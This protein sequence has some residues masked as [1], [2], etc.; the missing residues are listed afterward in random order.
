MKF[1]GLVALM[2][3]REGRY[4]DESGVTSSNTNSARFCSLFFTRLVTP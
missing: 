3:G 2:M 4:F 1:Y